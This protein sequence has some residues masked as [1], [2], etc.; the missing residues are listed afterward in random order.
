MKE[1]R[2]GGRSFP[3]LDFVVLHNND[4]CLIRFILI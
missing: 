1:E 2:G 4:V 3:M